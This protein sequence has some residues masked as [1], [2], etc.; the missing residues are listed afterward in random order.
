MTATENFDSNTLLEH[1]LGDEELG[2][3]ILAI[4]VDSA[5]ALLKSIES[6]LADADA[7]AVGLHSHSLKG[8][9]ANVGATLLGALARQ[10]E[11]RSKR[12]ETEAVRELLPAL[13]KAYDAFL[14]DARAT[15]WIAA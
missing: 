10:A 1:L 9:S 6:A 3:E 11:E 5:A 8:A 13:A 2:R 12:G 4:Y 7:Q 14:A 15:G